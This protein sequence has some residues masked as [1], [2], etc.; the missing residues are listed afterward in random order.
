VVLI[1]PADRGRKLTICQA[2][3]LAERLRVHSPLVFGAGSCAR[4]VDHDLSLARLDPA[5]AEDPRSERAH[6]RGKLV[7]DG[8]RPKQNQR[9]ERASRWHPSP[10]HRLGV[11][12]VGRLERRDAR[13]GCGLHR[14][15][16]ASEIRAR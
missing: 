7:V 11:R 4:P 10:E 13:P 14:Y 8:E 15:P 5:A 16:P 2:D 12:L 1:I 3:G 6:P 9:F